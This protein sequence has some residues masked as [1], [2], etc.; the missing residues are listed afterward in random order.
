MSPNVLAWDRDFANAEERRLAAAN[1]ASGLRAQQ[2]SPQLPPALRR[3]RDLFV[4]CLSGTAGIRRRRAPIS[5]RSL[6]DPW[7]LLLQRL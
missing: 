7:L 4:A 1:T 2:G 3:S 5:P 6:L